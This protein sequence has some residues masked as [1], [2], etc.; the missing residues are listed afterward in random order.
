MRLSNDYATLSVLPSAERL[1]REV[2]RFGYII[3]METSVPRLCFGKLTTD[4]I[5]LK[6]VKTGKQLRIAIRYFLLL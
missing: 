4:L 3:A 6:K 2:Y 1:H 5:V